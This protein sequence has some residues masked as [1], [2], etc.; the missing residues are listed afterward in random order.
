MS[1]LKDLIS[2]LTSTRKPVAP[3]EEEK[4]LNFERIGNVAILEDWNIGRV[5][6]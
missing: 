6:Y 4:S 3:S 1:I 5:E 2:L